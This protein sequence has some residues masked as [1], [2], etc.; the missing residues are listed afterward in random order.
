M[1]NIIYYILLI[2]F[3]NFLNLQYVKFLNPGLVSTW[4][5]VLGHRDKVC[6]V[7]SRSKTDSPRIT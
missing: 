5:F 2:F 1:W 4:R 7:S 6:H 3:K